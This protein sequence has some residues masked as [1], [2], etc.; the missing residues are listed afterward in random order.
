MSPLMAFF[1]LVRFFAVGAFINVMGIRH[2][3]GI[4]V[5]IVTVFRGFF[6]FLIGLVHRFFLPVSGVNFLNPLAY[7][8]IETP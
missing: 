4:V 7:K 8:A 3:V 2:R 6:I 1:L 5:M